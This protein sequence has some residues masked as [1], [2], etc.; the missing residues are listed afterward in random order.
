M[1]NGINSKDNLQSPS[2]YEHISQTTYNNNQNQPVQILSNQPVLYQI[3]PNQSN[4]NSNQPVQYQIQ[5]V[6]YQILTLQNPQVQYQVLPNQQNQY[7]IL[8]NLNSQIQYNPQDQN[9]IYVPPVTDPS[10]KKLSE[11]YSVS[12][13]NS[14]NYCCGR[15][16]Y[17]VTGRTSDGR[18][19]NLFKIV[20]SSDACNK[21]LNSKFSKPM[22][23][24]FYSFE[25]NQLLNPLIEIKEG[26][27][28][29]CACICQDV[30]IGMNDIEVKS[31]NNQ[32]TRIVK[33]EKGCCCGI[34]KK[35]YD[36]NGNLLYFIEYDN[37]SCRIMIMF[38][39]I[40]FSVIFLI[41]IAIVA[42]LSRGNIGGCNCC[43]E[44]N[45]IRNVYDK[46]ANVVG[47]IEIIKNCCCDCYCAC[48]CCYSPIYCI[49]F[50]ISMD[51]HSKLSLIGTAIEMDYT[52]L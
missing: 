34:E 6:Q 12:V 11:C 8:P 9:N 7:Q 48:C 3:L 38:L 52:N 24:K 2:T 44:R 45:V 43:N 23:L 39:L 47:S 26:R 33:R 14:Y 50:P 10:L 29:V 13:H 40:I 30:C 19:I 27:C 1:S 22:N 31:S 20:E 46:Y 25:D 42:V 16:Q 15:E 5:P 21:C 17:I 28:Y 18:E 51:T 37:C 49:N 36:I 32:L 35:I 41:I 4:Q